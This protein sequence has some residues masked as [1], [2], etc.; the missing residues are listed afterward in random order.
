MRRFLDRPLRLVPFL[1]VGLLAAAS[2][3]AVR[4]SALPLAA[5]PFPARGLVHLPIVFVPGL[6]TGV[7]V[8]PGTL[9]GLKPQYAAFLVGWPLVTL[10]VATVALA[11]TLWLANPDVDGVV[12]PATRVGWLGVYAL[13]TQGPLLLAVASPTV[14]QLD[15]GALLVLALGLVVLAA[16]L[17]LTPAFVVLE[18]RRPLAA[19]RA[20]VALVADRPLSIGALAVGL[21]YAGYLLTGVAHVVPTG[22]W[23]LPFGA[24][25]SPVVAGPL[26][27]LAVVETYRRRPAED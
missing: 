17:F 1:P 19:A 18:G 27:A 12:P 9:I 8:R 20:S 3:V 23:G 7:T 14:R 10:V 5:R 6:Q 21:A 16:G 24:A 22:T 13:L 26:Y 2:V 25:A 15:D 4:R 11:V